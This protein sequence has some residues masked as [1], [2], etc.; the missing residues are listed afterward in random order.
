MLSKEHVMRVRKRA[1]DMDCYPNPNPNPKV[2]DQD[3]SV[4]NFEKRP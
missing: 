1:V 2:I 3:T 4:G